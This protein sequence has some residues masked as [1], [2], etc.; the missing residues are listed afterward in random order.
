MRNAGERVPNHANTGAL[1]ASVEVK[2]LSTMERHQ[3]ADLPTVGKE[4]RTVRGTR[5]IVGEER[6]KV[7]SRVEIATTVIKPRVRVVE[8]N[9]ATILGH[10]VQFVGPRVSELGRQPVP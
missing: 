5:H 6:G 7:L 10:V 4:F 1:C 2:R 3:A 8:L 9:S